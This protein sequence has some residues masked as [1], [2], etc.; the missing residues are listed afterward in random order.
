MQ[1]CIFSAFKFCPWFHI[2]LGTGCVQDAKAYCTHRYFICR[3]LKAHLIVKNSSWFGWNLQLQGS[4]AL[5]SCITNRSSRM[6]KCFHPLWSI[7]QEESDACFKCQTLQGISASRNWPQLFNFEMNKMEL[8]ASCSINPIRRRY[9]TEPFDSVDI[10]QSLEQLKNN[11]SFTWAVGLQ[12][13]NL[14]FLGFPKTVV[15]VWLWECVHIAYQLKIF[16]MIRSYVCLGSNFTLSGDDSSAQLWASD[17]KKQ[18]IRSLSVSPFIHWFRDSQAFN[19]FFSQAKKNMFE[20][21]HFICGLCR[22]L[23][24]FLGRD[25]FALLTKQCTTEAW[26]T[27]SNW[28][29]QVNGMR[30]LCAVMFC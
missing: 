2:F 24:S 18:A 11:F 10:D 16:P 29:C 27:T 5:F 1:L 13:E 20:T 15:F 14:S 23:K 3:S 17:A 4:W 9:S 7:K 6:H 22:F 26:A 30:N 25:K 12:E 28:E 8:I 21:E 19:I